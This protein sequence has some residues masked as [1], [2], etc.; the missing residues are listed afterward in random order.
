M[1]GLKAW[2]KAIGLA[3]GG[4]PTQPPPVVVTRPPPSPPLPS[5]TDDA[6]A[7]LWT[8][9]EVRRQNGRPPLV[10]HEALSLAAWR[11]ARD[12]ATRDVLSHEGSDG[13]WPVARIAAAGYPLAS[14]SENGFTCDPWTGGPA[15]WGTASHAVL[16]WLHS[17]VGHREAL[18]GDWTHTGGARA[19][20][21]DG[22]IYW[23][24]CYGNPTH[25]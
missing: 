21:A 3:L 11:I 18:L 7:L 15:D 12:N 22:S 16:G 24:G 17:R 4:H 25:P 10:Y 1:F 13:S 20:A 23:F 2:L 14:G 9:N 5:L 19:V 6:L 8:T